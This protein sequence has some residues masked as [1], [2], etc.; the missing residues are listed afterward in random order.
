MKCY[1]FDLD[2]TLA[3]CEHRMHYISGDKKDWDA[4]FGAVKD[5]TPIEPMVHLFNCTSLHSYVKLVILTGRSEVCKEDTEKWLTDTGLYYDRLLMR[6]AKDRR[7]DTEVKSEMLDQLLAEG[8]RPIMAF[9]DRK[10]VV[11]MWRSRGILCAQVA[12]GNY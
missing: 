1:I 9:E 12:E 7:P 10:T 4:F 6:K 5:D 11:N 3:N 2:G 8:Y